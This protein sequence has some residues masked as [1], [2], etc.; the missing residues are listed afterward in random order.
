[1][2]SG[3]ANIASKGGRFCLMWERLTIGIVA[4][5][6]AAAILG[7]YNSMASVGEALAEFGKAQAVM[8]S[9]ILDVRAR[10]S[11]IYTREDAKQRHE[12]IFRT[13]QHQYSLLE[14][15]E[16]RIRKLEHGG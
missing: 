1:M 12:E 10:L 15:H 2:S 3:K 16:A 13:Q 6:L 14:D 7:V 9:Q 5:V 11:G 8:Q 4:P